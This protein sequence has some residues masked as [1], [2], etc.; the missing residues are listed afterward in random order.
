MKYKEEQEKLTNGI[1]EAQRILQRLDAEHYAS[2]KVMT[3]QKIYYGSSVVVN[4]SSR[5]QPIRIMISRWQEGLQLIENYNNN[6][7]LDIDEELTRIMQWTCSSDL[8]S[9]MEEEKLDKKDK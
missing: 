3:D 1:A 7:K 5:V 9:L 4:H 2:I 8:R 6:R